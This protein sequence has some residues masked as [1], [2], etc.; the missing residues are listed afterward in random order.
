[1]NIH[2]VEAKNNFI[3]VSNNEWESGWW[4]LE[5]SQAQKLVGGDIF[6]HKTRQ[7]PSY[8]GGRIL[9]YR[10][11]EDETHKGMIVFK[12]RHDKACRDIKTE[13]TGWFKAIKITGEDTEETETKEN[14]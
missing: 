13:K 14:E 12:L 3:K 10:I 7:E 4:K 8:Y 9:G 11:E 6:F 1:M 5:E 2:I